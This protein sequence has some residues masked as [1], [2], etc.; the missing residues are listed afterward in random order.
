MAKK[1]KIEIVRSDRIKPK[2]AT[3]SV[4]VKGKDSVMMDEKTRKSMKYSIA[5]GTLNAASSNITSTYVT[6]YALFLKATHSEIGILNALQNLA[7]IISQIPGA[8][9][10]NRMSRKSIWLFSIIATKLFWIPIL[11]LPF[12]PNPVWVFIILIFFTAFFASLKNPAWS[13]MM[14]DI[15]PHDIRGKYFG[16]RNSILGVSGLITMLV[17]GFIL[18][19]YGFSA[20]FL[21]SIVLGFVSI[22][23]FIKMYE[24]PFRR[25]YYYKHTLSLN[26]GNALKF[27]KVNRNFSLF[28]IYM[29]FSGFAI[30][31]AS[32]F[33]TVYMLK[34]LNIGYAWFA[35]IAAIG[36]LV[37][38]FSQ[39]YWGSL[40]D[41]FG[42]RKIMIICAVLIAFVP[43]G[44]MLSYNINHLIIVEIFSGFAWAGF[45][46]VTFNF[47]LG[48][49]P[50]DRRPSFVA[51]FNIFT[52]IGGMVGLLSGG[53]LAE[54]LQG[55]GFLFFFG[56]HALFALSFVLRIVSVALMPAI[57]Q[58]EKEDAT[59]VKD[60]FW[61]V[62]VE[63]PV[64]GMMH[65]MEYFVENPGKVMNGIERRI[66][67]I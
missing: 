42:S 28:T 11:L 12:F 44:Y 31:V 30:N 8:N 13:S 23:F 39:G 4:F 51:N 10:T 43:L 40:S 46:L 6:P 57:R 50:A 14:G 34:D 16:K 20:I 64:K 61:Q 5:E 38:I 62:V 3:K 26:F 9:L 52:G 67:K 37:R 66:R 24:P 47:L 65:R 21:I 63:H 22:I 27:V 53:F 19:V 2:I 45:D 55:S 17:S 59:P 32:P 58:I 33:F 41:R 49:T 48:V 25:N 36:I 35:I 54:V 29:T 15:V 18:S 60:L 7:V 56:L 1:E